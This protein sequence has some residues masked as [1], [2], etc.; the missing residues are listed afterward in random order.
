[1]PSQLV[2][3]LSAR[4]LVGREDF[5]V[6]SC[7]AQAVAFIDSWPNWPVGAV[8][9]F[10]PA[11]S[12]KTHLASIWQTTSGAHLA[13]AADL[14]SSSQPAGP[15]IVENVDLMAP[16]PERDVELFRLI[17]LARPA[18]PVLLTGN[19][20]P[21]TWPTALPDLASRFSALLSLPLWVP[22]EELLSALARKLFD[23][24]QVS[25]P[26]A[27]IERVVHSLERSPN[28]IRR[29]VAKADAKALAEARPINLA[30]V[31]ELMAEEN[32]GLS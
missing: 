20:A 16:T 32:D 13:S 5:V 24:R 6:T 26:D 4:A 10:G 31:R 3:P 14:G 27:V 9:I 25:V 30:L 2:L 11:G 18:S 8:V 19:E 28:A 22:D 21:S 7:N 12:G 15:L 23:D 17:D 29:F 1:M